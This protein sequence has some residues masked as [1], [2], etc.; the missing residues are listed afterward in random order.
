MVGTMGF[1]MQV[2][3]APSPSWSTN[4]LPQEAAQ[5]SEPPSGRKQR[6]C[7]ACLDAGRKEGEDGVLKVCKFFRRGFLYQEGESPGSQ[8]GESKATIL[9]SRLL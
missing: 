5:Q 3:S 9:A 8:Q 2:R 1:I 4:H 7:L 6:A